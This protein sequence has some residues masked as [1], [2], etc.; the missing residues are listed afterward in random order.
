MQIAHNPETG[1]YLG[2]I[3][4]QWQPVKVARNESTGEMLYQDASGGWKPAGRSQTAP[5]RSPEDPSELGWGEALWEGVKNI[6]AS[7][8]R[9]AGNLADAVLNPVDTAEAIW[10]TGAGAATKA[11]RLVN[12]DIPRQDEERYAEAVGQY[13]ADRYGSPE[14]IKRTI[15]YDLAGLLSDA[16][17]V[18]TGGAGLAKGA[19]ALGKGARAVGAAVSPAI[20]AEAGPLVRA[21]EVTGRGLSSAARATDPLGLTLRAPSAV[22][23]AAGFV[24]GKLGWEPLMTGGPYEA[25]AR[26]MYEQSLGLNAGFS[27]NS[28]ARF[29]PA[30]RAALVTAG[31]DEGLPVTPGGYGKAQDKISGLND[32][33]D[34][35]I[36]EADAAGIKVDP[37]KVAED[38]LN[39]DTRKLIAAQS[40]PVDDLNAFDK[41]VTEYY[42]THGAD[43]STIAGMQETKKATYQK[44]D[45]RYNNNTSPMAP[46][47]IEA[48]MELA[49]QQRLEIGRAVDEAHKQGLLTDKEWTSI[50][51]INAR[52]GNLLALRDAMER[53]LQSS[54]KKPLISALLSGVMGTATGDLS[55]GIAIGGAMQA[56]KSPWFR[57]QAALKLHNMGEIGLPSRAWTPAMAA[58]YAASNNRALQKW[59]EKNYPNRGLLDLIAADRK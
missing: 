38:A 13:A 31:L 21:M 35:A 18:F 20:S 6:P 33:I 51:D 8:G 48:D 46:G 39:S 30:E 27:N 7:A 26:K 37:Y 34:R 50:H 44:H 52:E 15:A 42:D 58:Q 22:S 23:D 53:A 16:A 32:R 14:G 2:L 40:T 19:A 12:P 36:A 28:K 29:S 11:A 25:L 56:M 17:T 41:A 49:R 9:L 10:K 57:S 45:R 54:A 47:H 4:G 59:Y 24:R 5:G 3:D 55:T 1:E 43:N